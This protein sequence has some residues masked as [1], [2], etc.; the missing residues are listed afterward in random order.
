MN[1]WPLILLPLCGCIVPRGDIVS[2]TTSGV[3]LSLGY[4]AAS[5]MPEVK[6]GFFRQT[7]HFVPSNSPPVTSS[8]SLEQHGLSAN[9]FEEFTTSGA[10]IPSNSVARAR[11][12]MLAP[13]QPAPM[14]HSQILQS[15]K[16]QS[17]GLLDSAAPRFAL[18]FNDTELRPVAVIELNTDSALN[19]YS[20]ISD[21]ISYPDSNPPLPK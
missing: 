2:V 3:G 19:I 13:K 1:L 4:N 8:L 10:T 6:I 14:P 15:P 20:V 11:A 9:I 7:F 18:L 17:V 16:A 12:G 21:P 5:Q